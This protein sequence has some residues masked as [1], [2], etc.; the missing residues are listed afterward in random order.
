MLLSVI[1]MFGR[2]ISPLQCA[3]RTA[4]YCFALFMK[5]EVP[6]LCDFFSCKKAFF[7][8][9]RHSHKQTTTNAGIE[10]CV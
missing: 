4:G 8:T 6:I 3:K 2:E 9:F 10:L 1:Y 5:T 7:S